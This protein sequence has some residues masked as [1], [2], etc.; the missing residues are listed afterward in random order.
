MIQI[1]AF[2]LPPAFLMTSLIL[3]MSSTCPFV[4]AAIGNPAHY[5]QP[6]TTPPLP[7]ANR[8]NFQPSSKSRWAI[9]REVGDGLCGFRS[10][11]R[12]ILGI[13]DLHAQIRNEVVQYLDQHRENQDF[14]ISTGIDT[15]NIYVLGQSPRTYKCCDDYLQIMSYSTTFMGQPEIIAAGLLYAKTIQVISTGSALPII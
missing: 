12:H 7:S 11:S 2:Y 1:C 14:N 8:S 4:E 10:L 15:E 6:N 5:S 13:P 3:S 9:F